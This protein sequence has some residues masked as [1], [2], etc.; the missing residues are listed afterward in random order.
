[1]IRVGAVGQIERQASVETTTYD[2]RVEASPQLV[3][4][5]RGAVDVG[6]AVRPPAA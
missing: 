2:I 4:R 3:P 5:P 6:S 1:M